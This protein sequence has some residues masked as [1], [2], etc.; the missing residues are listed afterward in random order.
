MGEKPPV[1][2]ETPQSILER[3]GKLTDDHDKGILHGR[4]FNQGRPAGSRAPIC[5][6]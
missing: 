3:E 5:P 2:K 1:L 6:E 4:T